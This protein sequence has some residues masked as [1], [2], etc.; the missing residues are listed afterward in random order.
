MYGDDGSYSYPNNGQRQFRI[1]GGTMSTEHRAQSIGYREVFKRIFLTGTLVILF[2]FQIEA[3]GEIPPFEPVHDISVN[4]ASVDFG[5]INLDSSLEQTVTVSN[6]G[7]VDLIIGTITEPQAPFSITT[8]NCSGQTLTPLANCAIIVKFAPTSIGLLN[9]DFNIPSDD[10][11]E[12]P[13]TT[14]LSG[15]GMAPGNTPPT[16]P[17]LTYP[18]NGAANM[19][20]TL[21]LKWEKS[22]DPDGD[23]VTYDLYICKDESFTT[24]CITKENIEYTVS[25]NSYQPPAISYYAGLLMFGIVLA[26]SVKGR[27]GRG[28]TGETGKRR[29][30]KKRKINL[31][32][33]MIMITGMILVSCGG[34]NGNGDNDGGTSDELSY[35]V[36]GLSAGTPYHWKVVADDG[37]GGL[38]KSDTYS[39]KTA[40]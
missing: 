5:N 2:G 3:Y 30:G 38:T 18:S 7:N 24:G 14:G 21:T 15:S 25:A 9:S 11:D 36:S 19:P 39:F 33:A 10:P 13:V 4:P 8:D 32:I 27:M 26:G 1:R 34:D 31:L 12:N 22:T 16:K 28:R 20:A 37:N 40:P 23:T 35:T 29:R 17:K 6:E